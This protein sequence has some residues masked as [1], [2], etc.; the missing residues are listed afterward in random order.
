MLPSPLSPLALMYTK[1]FRLGLA[2]GTLTLVGF[3]GARD[4]LGFHPAEG[5]SLTK[6]FSSE[7]TSS[8][9]SMDL[10]VD[11]ND[12]AGM[13]GDLVVA[14]ES[15]SE[16][17]FTDTYLKLE[18]G[19][20]R[21]LQRSFDELSSLTSISFGSQFGGESQ[22]I[23]VESELDGK[24]VLF[25]WDPEQAGFV[26]SMEESSAKDERLL[27]ALECETDLRFLLPEG[28]VELGAT[29]EVPL[30]AFKE[31]VLPSGDLSWMPSGMPAAE[32]DMEAFGELGEDLKRRGEELLR[33]AL[34]GKAKCTYLGTE[35]HEGKALGSIA[36]ELSFDIEIDLIPIVEEFMGTVLEFLPM[37]MD[38]EFTFDAL[39]LGFGLE[40]EGLALWDPKAGH[41]VQIEMHSDADIFLELNLEAEAE[42]QAHSLEMSMEMVMTMD[43]MAAFSE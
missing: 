15:H 29:W 6:H 17:I 19:G 1:R 41:L 43:N 14:A 12:I 10:V 28:E 16:L 32:L 5:L 38:L 8:L 36:I 39:N 9:E 37:D 7:S 18:D 42:G 31:L 23:D 34:K 20:L 21:R 40:A 30:I 33:K 27:K 11:G 3:G 13:L 35:L 25:T 26:A 2:L 22:D 24:T 4:R